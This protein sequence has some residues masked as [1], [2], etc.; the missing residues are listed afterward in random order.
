MIPLCRQKS[1]ETR[2]ILE[3]CVIATN[4]VTGGKEREKMYV[5]PEEL[6]SFPLAV[7]AIHPEKKKNEYDSGC[8]MLSA[9]W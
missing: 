9:A 1:I 5:C 8:M 7:P 6:H 4:H 2:T 3:L